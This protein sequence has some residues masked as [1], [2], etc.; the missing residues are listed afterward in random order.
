MLDCQYRESASPHNGR[1]TSYIWLMKR[2]KEEG[3]HLRGNPLRGIEDNILTRLDPFSAYIPSADIV[4]QEELQWCP[5]FP[6]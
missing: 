6:V 4:Y 1:G 2:R 5:V 3:Y